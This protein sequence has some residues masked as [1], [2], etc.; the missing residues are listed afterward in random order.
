MKTWR[1]QTFEKIDEQVGEPVEVDPAEMKMLVE[2]MVEEDQ[3][4]GRSRQY[5]CT[6]LSHEPVT[7]ARIPELE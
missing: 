6:P 3:R 5:I 4:L 7:S 1:I 2:L